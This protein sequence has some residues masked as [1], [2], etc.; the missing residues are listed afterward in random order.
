MQVRN[1]QMAHSTAH[2]ACRFRE[3]RE[4]NEKKKWT[5]KN[6]RDADKCFSKTNEV[7]SANCSTFTR[8]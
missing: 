7:S 6:E 8:M 1:V 5:K 4:K 2:N 3:S